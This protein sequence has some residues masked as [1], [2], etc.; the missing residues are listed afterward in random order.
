MKWMGK[1][2]RRDQESQKG[3]SNDLMSAWLTTGVAAKK[4]QR[5]ARSI[6]WRRGIDITNEQG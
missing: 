2:R 3:Q 1:K 6:R 4:L 5:P